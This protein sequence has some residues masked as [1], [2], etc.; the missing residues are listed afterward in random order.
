MCQQMTP[1]YLMEVDHMI[2]IVGLDMTLLDMDANTLVNRIWCDEFNLQGVDKQ[3]HKAKTKLENAERRKNKNE[4]KASQITQGSNQECGQRAIPGGND[5]RDGR[6]RKK[7]TVK[8][9]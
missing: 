8:A 9:N 1:T 5:S 4:R 7:R 3:C 6:N 2:P